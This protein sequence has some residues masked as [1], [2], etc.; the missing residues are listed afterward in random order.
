M[1]FATATVTYLT[2]LPGGRLDP[3]PTADVSWLLYEFTEPAGGLR[4]VRLLPADGGGELRISSPL[5]SPGPASVS[6]DGRRVAYGGTR[7][8]QVDSQVRVNELDQ[9]LR[10]APRLETGKA[11]TLKI[12]AAATDTVIGL[13]SVKPGAAP[14]TVPP[15][16]GAFELDAGLLFFVVAGIGEQSVV[17]GV[18]SDPAL[19]GAHVYVQG[20]RVTGF[21][22]PAGGFTRSA[23]A[24]VF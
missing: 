12:P 7:P 16:T 3:V 21:A 15:F 22:P 2:G 11:S 6:T 19:V 8:P 9:E 14:I 5:Q 18:P 13:L 10:L 23:A 4:T 17:L 1:D 24:R 20:L